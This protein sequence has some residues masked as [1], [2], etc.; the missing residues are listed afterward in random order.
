MALKKQSNRPAGD[1]D[2]QSDYCGPQAALSDVLFLLNRYQLS[3]L[4]VTDGQKLVGIITRTDIIRVEADQLGGFVNCPNPVPLPMW[5][6]KLV[7][8]PWE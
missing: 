7:P 5:F 2:S 8:R 3:R 4:P 1:H 6:I